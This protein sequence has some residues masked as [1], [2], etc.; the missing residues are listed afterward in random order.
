MAGVQDEERR[1]SEDTGAKAGM[2]DEGVALRRTQEQGERCGRAH[3][4]SQGMV[5]ANV[6]AHP[7]GARRWRGEGGQA[8]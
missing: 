8:R 3:L 6:R 4:Y 1:P 7:K 2:G 5:R